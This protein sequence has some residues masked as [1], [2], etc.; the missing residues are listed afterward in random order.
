MTLRFKPKLAKT[1]FSWAVAIVAAIL[2]FGPILPWRGRNDYR[3]IWKT[4]EAINSDEATNKFLQLSLLN[5]EYRKAGKSNQEIK[6]LAPRDA[7]FSLM[8]A[9]SVTTGNL[10]KN[11]GL[12]S[13]SVPAFLL[14]NLIVQ[15]VYLYIADFKVDRNAVSIISQ[16]CKDFPDRFVPPS[17]IPLVQD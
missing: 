5:K 13:S 1:S 8:V 9:N 17:L 14:V 3:P 12:I 4:V 11:L 10:G 2:L 7:I 6:C 16:K 15:A